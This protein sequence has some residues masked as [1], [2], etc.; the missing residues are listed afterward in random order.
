MIHPN[1]RKKNICSPVKNVSAIRQCFKNYYTECIILTSPSWHI[2]LVLDLSKF[3][4]MTD[5]EQFR[6]SDT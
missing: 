1:K 3:L 2:D 5:L 6:T 4:P